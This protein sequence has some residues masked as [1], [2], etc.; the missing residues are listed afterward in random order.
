MN[1]EFYDF[2]KA[3][4][5]TFFFISKG[6]RKIDKV[7]K[8][9]KISSCY[10]RDVYN[11]GFGDR[12]GGTSKIDDKIISNNGDIYKV[13]NTVLQT[14]PEFFKKYP[15]SVLFVTGSDNEGEKKRIRVY[16]YFVNKNFIWI[17]KDYVMFG[18]IIENKKTIV[19][20]YITGKDYFAIL[21]YKKMN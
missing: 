16:R 3:D 10:D 15:K 14:I 12:I 5:L 19:E 13:F 6:R 21:I 9:Q 11:F 2:D 20:Q 4:D 17:V 8:Y 18:Y 1:I 7:V